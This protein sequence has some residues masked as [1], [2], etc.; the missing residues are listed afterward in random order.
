MRTSPDALL[1]QARAGEEAGEAAADDDDILVVG[2]GG[3]GVAGRD[4]G[5]VVVV[6]REASGHRDV[7]VG[8]VGAQTLVALG[9][10][11]LAQ[12]IGVE[13]EVCGVVLVHGVSSALLDAGWENYWS[14]F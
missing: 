8:A 10:V 2:D 12:G 6:V 1:F 14:A 13:A 3:A 5:I 9:A 11:F 7:L 4:I